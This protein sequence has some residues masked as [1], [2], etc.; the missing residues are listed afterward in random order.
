MKVFNIKIIIIIS[1]SEMRISFMLFSSPRRW[2][3]RPMLKERNDHSHFNTLI[4][5]QCLVNSSLYFNF[6]MMS[7]LTFEKLTQIVAPKFLRKT[8]RHDVLSVGEILG[9]TFSL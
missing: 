6:T 5:E 1:I 2:H 9:A 8:C 7:P 3:V 4:K